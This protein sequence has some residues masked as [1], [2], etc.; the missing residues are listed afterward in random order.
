MTQREM[1]RLLEQCGWTRESGGKH[2]KMVKPGH[3][4]ITL[5]DHKRR[6]YPVGLYRAILK[7]AG[8]LGEG[9]G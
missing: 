5:P 1:I 6:D 3:R 7:Q 9:G 2:I 4:P 8:I